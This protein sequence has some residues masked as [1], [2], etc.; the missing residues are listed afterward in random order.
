[1]PFLQM[2]MSFIMFSVQ[3]LLLWF[4]E[5][6]KFQ[7]SNSGTWISK[8]CAWPFETYLWV[9]CNF[10]ILEKLHM[11]EIYAR[12]SINGTIQI[13]E[14][15][16]NMNSASYFVCFWTKNCLEVI[17]KKLKKNLLW[18][19]LVCQLYVSIRVTTEESN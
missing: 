15:F 13:K 7:E 8:A 11:K 17:E 16:T 12:L 6:L 10:D 18:E 5:T 2:K 4:L 1:M 14:S 19:L 9:S 3:L